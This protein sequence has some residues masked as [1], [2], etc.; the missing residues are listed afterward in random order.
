MA[1]AGSLHILIYLTATVSKMSRGHSEDKSN[2]ASGVLDLPNGTGR[3][4]LLLLIKNRKI[5]YSRRLG[6]G[7]E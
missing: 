3:A 1:K 6:A 7:A 5:E 2:M 4:G